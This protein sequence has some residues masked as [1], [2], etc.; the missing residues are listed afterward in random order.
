MRANL[1]YKAAMIILCAA[2][3]VSCTTQNVVPE[4]TQG[5][6]QQVINQFKSL[7]IDARNGTFGEV[8]NP[9]TGQIQTGYTL[10]GDLFVSE[11]Q[12]Q[13]M[14]AKRAS[15]PIGEQYRSSSLVLGLPRVIKVLGYTGGSFALTTKMRTALQW[16]VNNYNA[17]GL[18][19]TFT[20]D[21]GTAFSTY[22]MVVYK[23]NGA[24]AGGS[25]G[26]PSGGNP[27]K[28]IQIFA[29]TESFSTNVNEHVITHQMGHCL[30]LV[31]T[32]W[33]NNS[34]SCGTGGSESIVA[35]HI[36]GTGMT[37]TDPNFDYDSVMLKCFPSGAT[38]ELSIQD[39]IALDYL[40]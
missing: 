28:F 17:A 16:A 38:G 31:H 18:L 30:G 4:P 29:G 8:R 11:E 6:S 27:Y 14:L 23:T 39:K 34:I 19:L 2:F 7:H 3:T 15:H 13:E 36:P 22:D 25:S 35:I 5:I 40:Y 10:E 12:F 24:G 1:S 37:N 33:F 20:L 26:L 32:D 9:L 21:F